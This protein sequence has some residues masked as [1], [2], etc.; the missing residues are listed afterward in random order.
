MPNEP[1]PR[2]KGKTN[3]PDVEDSDE[4][5]DWTGWRE[6]ALRRTL[7]T[8]RQCLETGYAP[9]DIALLV[10]EN[11]DVAR[12][13][14]VLR[15]TLNVPVASRAL[16]AVK[17]SPLVRVLVNF[18]RWLNRPSDRLALVSAAH[19]Y[20]RYILELPF[21]WGVVCS[22]GRANDGPSFAAR[23]LGTFPPALAE[24]VYALE[25]LDIY[26]QTEELIQL[27]D[28][29]SHC[30]AF[31]LFF[32]EQMHTFIHREGSD[33]IAFLEWWAEKGRFESIPSGKAKGI[34]VMT[35]HQSKGLEFPVVI[36]P[37]A[38]WKIE[39]QGGSQSGS[40][41]VAAEGTEWAAQG[42]VLPLP[43][44]QAL[45]GTDFADPWLAHRRSH[46]VEQVNLLYVALTRAKERLYVFAPQAQYTKAGYLTQN[47]NGISA[48]LRNVLAAPL[49]LQGDDPHG[50]YLIRSEWRNLADEASGL[51]YGQP[52][53]PRSAPE[54]QAPA[55]EPFDYQAQ[56]WRK[57]LVIRPRAGS[58]AELNS[59]NWQGQR[60]LLWGSLVHG[61]LAT[62]RHADEAQARIESALT[63]LVRNGQLTAELRNQLADEL[64]ALLALPQFQEWLSPTWRVRT[65]AP[66]LDP[67]GQFHQPDRVLTAEDGRAVVIDFKTGQPD[68]THT[69]QVRRYRQK[70]VQMGYRPV[71][72]WLVY[73]GTEPRFVRVDD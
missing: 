23:L 7:E 4:D 56:P 36:L 69:Q 15:S 1:K 8:V 47:C 68:A 22:L 18:L 39:P 58:W 70:L 34:R 72:G 65:E 16:Q 52:E 53:P 19:D 5:N 32:L 3:E 71:E 50:P 24:R 26:E 48:L 25:Q 27:L 33:A 28:V 10:R 35:L 64:S 20:H 6:L 12:L 38:E 9:S 62:I 55:G 73:L 66:I 2:V 67:T 57:R 13:S 45:L 61:V 41:W 43:A 14:Q 11:R 44:S 40:L 60:Q 21:N 51:E 42:P 37:F 46:V 29:R 17:A 49:P 31:V 30:D 63:N 59:S 54:A